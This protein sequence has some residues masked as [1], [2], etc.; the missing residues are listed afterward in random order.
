[1]CSIGSQAAHYARDAS[2][3]LWVWTAAVS[4]G[5]R[6]HAVGVSARRVLSQ[7]RTRSLSRLLTIACA[8]LPFACADNIALGTACGKMFRCGVLSIIDVGDSD[9]LK[10]QPEA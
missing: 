1:M 2:S 4:S 7:L 10:A 8:P 3:S 6:A 9:I 5:G